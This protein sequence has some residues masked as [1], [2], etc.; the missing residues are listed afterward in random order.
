MSTS[1]TTDMWGIFITVCQKGST[2]SL[3]LSSA[4]MSERNRYVI[5]MNTLILSLFCFL[6]VVSA[7]MRHCLRRM[8]HCVDG[9][10]AFI[11]LSSEIFWMLRLRLRASSLRWVL[12]KN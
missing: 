5:V 11:F 1:M 9:R 6:S 10:D 3:L 12:K 2:L 7:I 4:A 8:P